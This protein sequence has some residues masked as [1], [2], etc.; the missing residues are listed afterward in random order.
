MEIFINENTTRQNNNKKEARRE[1][2]RQ[3]H[4]GLSV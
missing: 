4:I 1:T 3:L 2:A